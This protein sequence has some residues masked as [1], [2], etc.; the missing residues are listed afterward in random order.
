[1]IRVE[2]NRASLSYV[3]KKLGSLKSKAPNVIAKALNKTAKQA[4]KKL[5]IKAQETYTVKN[6]GFNR[7][8]TIK[9]ATAGSLESTIEATGAPLPLKQFKISK[10]GKTVRA[11]VLK[12]G[13]L[14]PLEKSGIKAFVNNIAKRG[15]TRKRNSKKGKAGSS[16][17]HTAV[18][19]REGA[20]RLPIKTFYSNSIPKMIGNEK[21]VYGI[22]KPLIKS[23][24]KKNIDEQ[25]RKLVR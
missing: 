18:A 24:L 22:V 2:V 8:M 5:A 4:R 3:E 25:I 15:Q 9:N 17:S 13:G 23:D 20:G 12:A 21:R 6:A 10:S 14:K 11:Q 1:M 19:Q 16:V 7:G